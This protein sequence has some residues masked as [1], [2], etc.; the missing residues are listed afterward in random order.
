[1]AYYR[2]K[3]LSVRVSAI[4]KEDKTTPRWVG[5]GTGYDFSADKPSRVAKPYNLMTTHT[6]DSFYKAEPEPS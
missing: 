4:L 6:V 2:P 5:R 3:P 1:M